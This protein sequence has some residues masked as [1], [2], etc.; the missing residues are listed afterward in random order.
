MRSK[1]AALAG[2]GLIAAALTGCATAS[3]DS[4]PGSSSEAVTATGEFGT[5]PEVEFPTPLMSSRTECSVLIEGDGEPI[6]GTQYV[7]GAVTFLNGATGQVIQAAGYDDA[8]VELPLGQFPPGVADGISCGS[9]GGRVAIVIPPDE[10]YGPQGMQL[11]LDTEDRLVLVVDI[12]QAFPPRADGAVQL[13]KD[14]F[15]AVV[16]APDGRPGITVPKKDAPE[17]FDSEVLKAGDG[18]TVQDGD[19]VVVHY[20][21]VLWDD[22]TVFDSSWEDGAPVAF[23]VGE[24]G[25]V[26]PGFSKAIVG[27]QVGSQVVAIIP[28]EDGYGDQVAGSIPAGSTLVFVI[29]ILG[30]A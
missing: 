24:N 6:T 25:E 14:G 19:R 30:I 18:E 21:G 27:Q 13:S 15:P 17:E 4:A 10:G 11:G 26:V 16:L 3:A 28:P 1:I 2:I 9:E 29:D 12:V 7:Q 23:Q 5:A 22:N 8:P 20:T